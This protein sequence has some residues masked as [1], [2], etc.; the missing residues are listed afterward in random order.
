MYEGRTVLR[1][2]DWFGHENMGEV[3][4]VGDGVDKVKVGKH[5]VLPF[6]ISGGFCKNCERG[7]TNH[8]VTTQPEP[9]MAGAA[10]R[11][12]PPGS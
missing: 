5:V 7:Y 8:C 12:G 9:T 2:D 3:V 4:E 6:N 11:G 1:P 10:G